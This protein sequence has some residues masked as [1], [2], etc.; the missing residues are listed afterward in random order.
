MG[1]ASRW[2]LHYSLQALQGALKQ[3]GSRLILRQGPAAQVF[4]DLLA[5]TKATAIYWNRRY[6]PQAIKND[7]VLKAQFQKEGVDVESFAGNV[8]FEPWTVKTQQGNP[9][10]VFTPFWRSCLQKQAAVAPV[11]APKQILAPATWP[12][13]NAVED[14]ALLPHMDWAR[15]FPPQWSPGEAGAHAHLETFL[16][17]ALAQYPE[18][19]NKPALGGT[20][21]LSPYLHFGEISPRQIWHAVQKKTIQSRQDGIVHGADVFL[22]E[23]GWR[24]FAFH[25]L[26]HFPRTP[27]EP[28]RPAFK[29]SLGRTIQRRCLLG[30]K[31]VPAT[32][33]SMQACA[34]CG[35]Q[36]GCIIGCA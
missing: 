36:G 27:E 18:D 10:Q 21:R 24:E 31:A 33:S 2:W 16:E 32:R 23:I 19:R 8:L 7:S 3:R 9:F 22:K 34:N 1:S 17:G 5:S 15:G 29:N 20:S 26:Y 4:R 35:R 30:K 6:E 14:F 11:A 28:L 25:L 13:S 12:A